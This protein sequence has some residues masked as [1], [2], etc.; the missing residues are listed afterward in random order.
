MNASSSRVQLRYIAEGTFGVTPNSGN[1]KELRMTGES[2][3]TDRAKEESKE[4]RADRQVSGATTV[5]AN[6]SGSIN[7]HLSY[8]EYD[9]F[10]AAALQSSFTVFGT[11]GV[12][13]TTTITFATGTLTASVSTSGASDWSTL[14]P[15]QWFLVV[16]PSNA[17]NGKL[18]RVS[19]SVAPTADVITLDASTPATAASNIANCTI[20]T[21]RLTNGVTQPSFSIEKEF[22]DI[23]QF[24]LFT[25]MT[26]NKVSL[27]FAAAAL[28]DGSVEFMGKIGALAGST[29]LPGTPVA[30]KTY[31][32][33]NG[34]TGI[35]QLWEGTAPVSGTFIKSMSMNIDNT[36]RGQKALANLGNIGIGVGDF[37]VSGSMEVYFSNG[38]MYDKFTDDTYTQI[39][40]G[41]Q[42]LSRNGYVFTLP[43]VLLMG[44]NITAGAKNQDVMATFEYMAF[45]DDANANAALRKTMFIDRVG[46]A[47]T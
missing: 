7:F 42:D 41:S 30:S 19:T 9:A 15:G 3:N 22:S 25:G 37:K 20:A 47:V 43:R 31:E 5:D 12:S 29:G 11:N 1:C 2:L 23:T 34:V 33:M 35:G 6:A 45:A 18:L 40:V 26:V 46:V 24:M 28:T 44:G 16:A 39:I 36:L 8:A 21:S 14:K 17:N 27:N 38:D 32:I 13:A 10:L 4:M